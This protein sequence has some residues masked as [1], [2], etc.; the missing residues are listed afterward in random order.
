MEQ[1]SAPG[2]KGVRRGKGQEEREGPKG[3]G[4]RRRG[5]GQEREES[6]GW[7]TTLASTHS[8]HENT[9]GPTFTAEQGKPIS[10]S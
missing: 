2:Q 8:A 10:K 1:V 3:G 6:G 4:A 5:R 9:R 7:S